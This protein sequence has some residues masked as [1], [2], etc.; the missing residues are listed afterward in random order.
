[1][2]RISYSDEEDFSGQFGLWQAN[3]RRSI[4]GKAGQAALRELEQA[5]LA[6]PEK[7]LISGELFNAEGDVCAI[8]ALARF[9]GVT[10]TQSDPDDD[11]EE[12]GVELGMPRLVAWSVVAQ[13]DH[14]IDGR[15]VEAQGPTRNGYGPRVY[16]PVTCEER[17]ERVLAWVQKQI[18]KG[19]AM[20]QPINQPPQTQAG[21]EQP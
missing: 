19:E 9:R 17:Y 7:A 14:E 8:G 12:V 13:N 3:C 5:L 16:V 10:E 2:S 21:A 18:A 15:W 1:M 4:Q 6:L 20:P 11:M